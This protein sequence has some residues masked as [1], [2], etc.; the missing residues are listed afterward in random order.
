VLDVL[1]PVGEVGAKTRRQSQAQR[2][3]SDGL[4]AG[5]RGLLHQPPS[6]GQGEH[7]EE[8]RR[9]DR[10]R[11]LTPVHEYRAGA[12]HRLGSVLEH[13][14]VRRLLRHTTGSATRRQ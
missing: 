1:G 7:V 6:T 8:R 13:Q 4:G 14:S 5:Q 11:R 10:A 2:V 9:T 12:T 3:G